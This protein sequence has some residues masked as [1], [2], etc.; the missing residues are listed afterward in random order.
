MA[1]IFLWGGFVLGKILNARIPPQRV[2]DEGRNLRWS[3]LIGRAD[4]ILR[5]G[6]SSPFVLCHSWLFKPPE[7]YDTF[8]FQI[9]QRE[10]GA[11]RPVV[12]VSLTPFLV[13]ELHKKSVV[14]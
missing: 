7:P 8:F 10:R 5:Q 12:F 3:P 9:D 13:L 4:D 14:Q 6:R 2:L 11:L 1:A